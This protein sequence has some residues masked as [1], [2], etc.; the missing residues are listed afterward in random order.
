MGFTNSLYEKERYEEVLK[1]A[2]DIRV[3]AERSLGSSRPEGPETA[4]KEALLAEWLASVGD[5]VAGYV[6]PKVA[7]GAVV[8]DSQSRLLLVQRSDTGAWLYPTGW[9]D[10]G[11]SPAE[12]VVKEV[13][14]E[15]G[16]EVEVVRLLGVL[17]GMRLQP[18]ALAFYT[19]VFHCRVLGGSLRAHPLECRQVGFFAEGDLPEPLAGNGRWKSL[20]FD[21]LRGR[22]R[23]PAFDPPRKAPWRAAVEDG[24]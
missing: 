23:Q 6:T 7:V 22:L 11:Y 19:L 24:S 21:A 8:G 14:E 16:I 4:G 12:V 5:G 9:A 17:D 20:A 3:A 13:W 1:V 18:S 10:V 15:T 2:A